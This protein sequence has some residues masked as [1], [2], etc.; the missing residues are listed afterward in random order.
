MST[1]WV[2]KPKR[3]Y[4]IETDQKTFKVE[5]DWLD[6]KATVAYLRKQGYTN[7]HINCIGYA[8]H[9]NY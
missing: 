3:L 6:Y 1:I 9:N 5:R 2:N 7:I 8:I 4:I